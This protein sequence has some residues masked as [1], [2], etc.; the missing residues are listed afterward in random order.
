MSGRVNSLAIITASE[1]Y[2][3]GKPVRFG[4]QFRDRF[5]KFGRGGDEHLV[6]GYDFNVISL[7]YRRDES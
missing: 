2:R 1:A 5:R 7:R 4:P 6:S 3:V